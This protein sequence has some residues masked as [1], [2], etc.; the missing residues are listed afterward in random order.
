MV[1]S[2]RLGSL[3]FGY[4]DVGTGDTI[5]LVHGHPFNRTMWSPQ[6][7]FFSETHRVIAPDLRGYGDS[8]TEGD[9]TLLEV[10]AHDLVSLLDALKIEQVILGGLSMG[11]QIALEFAISYPERICAL[12][13]ADTFATLD[14]ELGKQNRRDTADRLLREGMTPYA[15]EV[16]SKMAAPVNIETQPEMAWQVHEMMRAASPKG[17]AAALRGRAERR[18]YLPLLQNIAV[19]TLIVV[20]DLDEFTPISDA[21]VMHAHIANS[22]LEII[23]GAGHLPNLEKTERFNLILSDFLA[24]AVR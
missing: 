22:R 3:K 4:E 13:L 15:D 6:V 23:E 8:E 18:D 19:P 5:L 1:S 16:L 21:E 2:I 17:A 14:T 10:F 11:G 24:E 7:R 20:G 9:K 12:L